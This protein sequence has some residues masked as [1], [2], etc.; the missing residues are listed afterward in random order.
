MNEENEIRIRT[1][2]VEITQG[3]ETISLS[4]ENMLKLVN[5]IEDKNISM[6]LKGWY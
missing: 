5:D 6:K 1:W 2:G 4:K 3:E